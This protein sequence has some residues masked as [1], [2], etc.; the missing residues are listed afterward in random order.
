MPS[1]TAVVRAALFLATTVWAPVCSAAWAAPVAFFDAFLAALF[2]AVL[3]F[4]VL[5]LAVLFFAG[6]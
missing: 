6:S 2:F 3:F 1:P 4:A 5:F